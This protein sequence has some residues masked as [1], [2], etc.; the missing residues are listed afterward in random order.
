MA[1]RRKSG[2]ASKPKMVLRLLDLEQSKHA[3][4]NS[5][6]AGWTRRTFHGSNFSEPTC[7][8]LWQEDDLAFLSKLVW[9]QENLV[10]AIWRPVLSMAARAPSVA[11]IQ[12]CSR[13]VRCYVSC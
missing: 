4:L 5:S 2:K 9:C 13:S 10:H 3:V 6:T 11:C 7:G 8:Q 1:H 12:Q